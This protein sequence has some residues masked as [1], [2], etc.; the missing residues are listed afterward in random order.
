M[1][2]RTLRTAAALCERLD[3]PEALPVLEQVAQRYA[4]A[5]TPAMLDRIGTAD[6]AIGRQFVPTAAE[7]VQ[8][9][10]ENADPVGDDTHSPVTGIVHRYA[11]RVLLKANHACAVYCRFCFRREM[12]GPDGE[13]PLSPAQLDAAMAYVAG[14]PEIWEV[15]VTG[16]DPL[17]L[18]PRRLADVMARLAR[19]EHVKVVRFHTRVPAV[20]P[21]RVTP[22]LVQALQAPGKTTWVAL[23]AN[24]A[25]ELTSEA[26]AACARIVDAGIPMVSQTVLLKGVND[27]PEV[28]EALMR[29][30]VELRIKPYYLHHPDL[31]PGTGHFRSTLDEGQ[32][33][34]RD[35]RGRV[36]GLCQ[37][38]YVLDIP[39]GHGKAPVGPDYLAEGGV[40]DPQGQFHA[41]PPASGDT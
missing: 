18:S 41:Y 23:H 15:I 5:I 24:H 31:A 3:L 28:L 13:R 9:P 1:S 36:S 20:D 19:I 2:A 34:L 4:V 30:F 25:D 22:E 11:D 40:I 21:E 39:G 38:T 14:R 33:L 17:I 26:A 37:P 32:A 6:D 8:T 12:V 27:R 35:L 10:D 16:G 7:L 29:R